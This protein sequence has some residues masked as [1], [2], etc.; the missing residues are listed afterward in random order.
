MDNCKLKFESSE[1]SWYLLLLNHLTSSI[2]NFY[3][4]ICSCVWI[5]GW[6]WKIDLLCRF[7]IF[8]RPGWSIEDYWSDQTSWLDSMFFLPPFL[9]ISTLFSVHCSIL[10]CRLRIDPKTLPAMHALF[11]L[12]SYGFSKL[13]L[14]PLNILAPYVSRK[15]RHV[16]VMSENWVLKSLDQY[17]CHI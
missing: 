4:L 13:N 17:N 1:S 2:W 12:Q 6:E 11:L 16:K 10:W 9:P 15:F 8:C 3:F 14:W 5:T 7:R